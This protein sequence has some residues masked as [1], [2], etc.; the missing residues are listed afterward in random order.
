MDQ[1]D[2]R[3]KKGMFVKAKKAGWVWD[4]NT[5]YCLSCAKKFNYFST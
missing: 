2:V 4:K 3:T 5:Y 1:I